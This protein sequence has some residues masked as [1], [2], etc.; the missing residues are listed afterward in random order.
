MS[1]IQSLKDLA[2][3]FRIHLVSF[4]NLGEDLAA[5]FSEAQKGLGA[6]M[7]LGILQ[8]EKQYG[9]LQQEMDKLLAQHNIVTKEVGG[10]VQESLGVKDP[11]EIEEIKKAARVCLHFENKLIEEIEEVIDSEAEIAHSKI[12]SKIEKLLLNPKE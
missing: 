3:P 4:S 2:A 8:K 6:E 9:P 5:L 12:S 10:L 1:H 7:K 11:E